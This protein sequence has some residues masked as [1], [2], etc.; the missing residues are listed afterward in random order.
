MT[1][2][3]L[4]LS[5]RI[6]PAV[7]LLGALTLPTSAHADMLWYNGNFDL[8]DAAVNQNYVPINTGSGYM[9]EKA[10]VYDNFVVPVGQT[11]TITNLFTYNQV[12]YYV[13]PTKAAW[14]IRSGVSAG[15]GGTLLYSG[16][17]A[18]TATLTHAADYNNYIDPEYQVSVA[19]SIKLTAGTYWMA[20][21]PDSA[22]YYGDQSYIE[23]TSGA[24]AVG[25]PP[26]NDG[27][28]FIGNNL[29]GVGASNF[30]ASNL[31]FSAGVIGTAATTAVPE[32]ASFLLLAAGLA[33]A[34][35]L[36]R[37]HAGQRAA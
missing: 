29:T 1:S 23:T 34:P 24:G 27:R 19:V 10:F 30:V 7:L 37:R 14:E 21:A 31:D 16:D 15:N 20:V 2:V 4:S 18:A 6:L 3:H 17:S 35:W 12:A 9:L 25:T 5:R 36:I 13:A 22:G 8:N 32:P 33:G 11:W 26:G 28:S